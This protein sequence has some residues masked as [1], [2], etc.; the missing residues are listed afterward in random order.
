MNE[1]ESAEHTG[2]AQSSKIRFSETMR[3][4]V[5]EASGGDN[6]E[7]IEGSVSSESSEVSEDDEV[8][9]SYFSVR[10]KS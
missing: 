10:A 3:H 5:L 8:L 4:V 7:E 6:S 2:K 9:E 1:R